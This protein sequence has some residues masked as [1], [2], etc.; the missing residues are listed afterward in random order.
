MD[1]VIGGLFTLAIL[2]FIGYPRVSAWMSRTQT[3]LTA[4]DLNLSISEGT[5]RWHEYRRGQE[6][7]VR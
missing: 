7:D 6:G 1:W 3:G 5:L 2:W 4:G